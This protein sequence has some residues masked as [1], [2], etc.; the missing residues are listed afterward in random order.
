MRCCVRAAALISCLI[1]LFLTGCRSDL[2][3]CETIISV[4]SD[5]EVTGCRSWTAGQWR[6]ASGGE[7]EKAAW[8]VTFTVIGTAQSI[9]RAMDTEASF[10]ALEKALQDD[11][12]RAGFLETAAGNETAV[13]AYFDSAPDGASIQDFILY[14]LARTLDTQ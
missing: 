8:Y 12:T 1:V 14:E 5:P 2:P 6:E 10:A 11:E 3:S 4:V 7:K 13:T 9:T